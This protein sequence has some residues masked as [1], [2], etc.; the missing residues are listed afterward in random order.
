M[1]THNYSLVPDG[2]I[3][4]FKERMGKVELVGVSGANI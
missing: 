4:F 2:M 3:Q 1:I